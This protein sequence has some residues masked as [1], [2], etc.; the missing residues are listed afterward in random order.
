MSPHGPIRERFLV[1]GILGCIFL[2][3]LLSFGLLFSYARTFLTVAFIVVFGIGTMAL[4]YDQYVP[5]QP[6]LPQMLHGFVSVWLPCVPG[7]KTNF[8]L[9]SSIASVAL[10]LVCL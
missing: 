2:P 10:H 4:F 8:L 6:S 3:K 5:K 1:F 7:F 9:K